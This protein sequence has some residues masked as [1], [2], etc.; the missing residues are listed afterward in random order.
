M[1]SKSQLEDI[2]ELLNKDLNDIS[3]ELIKNPVLLSKVN[4]VSLV[5][6]IHCNWDYDDEFVNSLKDEEIDKFIRIF[7]YFEKLK[8]RG[9]GTA[10]PNLLKKLLMRNYRDMES[11]FNWVIETNNGK[12]P[13]IPLNTFKG[14]DCKTFLEYLKRVHY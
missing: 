2:K 14:Q 1:I 11:L 6:N 13:Y 10:I 3:R 7:S 4:S 5:L 12:N 9:S 8:F